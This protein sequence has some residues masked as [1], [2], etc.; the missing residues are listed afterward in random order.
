MTNPAQDG[1][2]VVAGATGYVGGRLVPTLLEQGRTVR[3]LVRRPE[4][5]SLPAAVQRVPGDVVA[6]RGLEEA[7]DGA[8]TA[9]YLVHS[10]GR[11]SGSAE[12]F[13]ERDRHGARNFGRAARAAGVRRVVYLAGLGPTDAAGSKPLRSRHEVAEILGDLV[14]ELVYVR[15]AMVIGAESASFRM[16]RALV[17]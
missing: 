15:A 2:V 8:H 12:G 13:D 9:Y 4:R 17:E 16:L 6:G 7:L 14:P 1:T 11:G 5:A 3:A 10:M